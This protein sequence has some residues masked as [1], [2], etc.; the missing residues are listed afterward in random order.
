MLVLGLYACVSM[1]NRPIKRYDEQGLNIL[2]EV[3]AEFD[4]LGLYTELNFFEF[5]FI[6][7]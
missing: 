6:Y 1:C 7:Y 2:R 4:I 3:K 5:E